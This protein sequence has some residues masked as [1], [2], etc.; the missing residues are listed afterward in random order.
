MIKKYI[1]VICLNKKSGI[2]KPLYLIWDN[3]KKIPI[4]KIKDIRPNVTLKT[5]EMGLR[6]TC[7]FDSNREKHLYYD[8]GKWYVEMYD[9]VL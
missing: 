3:E 2:I 1:D 5:G 8:R 6:Y 4:L 7:I 9:S